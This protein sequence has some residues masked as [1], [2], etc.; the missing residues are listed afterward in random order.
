MGVVVAAATVV[1]LLMLLDADAGVGAAAGV[2]AAETG[3]TFG[4][5]ALASLIVAS[6][7]F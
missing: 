4:F 6:S 7:A 3:A 1:G 5:G 2:A